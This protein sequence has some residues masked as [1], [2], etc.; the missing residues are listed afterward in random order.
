[1]PEHACHGQ[2]PLARPSLAG[3]PAERR[4][5]EELIASAGHQDDAVERLAVGR[6]FVAVAAGGR[7][8]LA[9]TLGARPGPENQ[10]RLAGLPGSSLAE[11]AGLL[12]AEEPLLASVGL[13]ALNAGQDVPAGARPMGAE[14][15]LMDLGRG[16]RVVVVGDFPFLDRLAREASQL[17]VLEMRPSAGSLAV[18]EWDQALASCQVAALTATAL[19]TRAMARLLAAAQNAVRVIVGP[20]TPWSARLLEQGADILAGS[21]VVEPRAVMEAVEQGLPFHQIKQRGVRSLCWGGGHSLF[22]PE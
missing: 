11:A 22:T 10:E 12:L 7:V 5:L 16:R 2:A 14:E 9:S 17:Q 21:R 15:L 1:M 6:R 4:L 19:L 8:G 3:L 20:S 18:E 13:A